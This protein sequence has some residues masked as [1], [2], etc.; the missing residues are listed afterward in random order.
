MSNLENFAQAVTAL[1]EL[2]D[3]NAKER[4]DLNAEY[5]AYMKKRRKAHCD[6]EYR[7]RAEGMWTEHAKA[8]EALEF[9][10][11]TRAESITPIA[12]AEWTLFERRDDGSYST[13]G[14]GAGRY[15]QASA[16]MSADVARQFNIPVEVR[17]I[18]PTRYTKEYGL[19]VGGCWEVYV[20]ADAITCEVLRRKPG[21]TLLE[22]VRLCW[23]RGVNPRVFNPYL[24][25]GYEEKVGLDFFG[26]EVPS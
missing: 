13:Q 24:P 23:K 9:H 21:P 25:F 6:A 3:R 20:R 17:R 5:Q 2:Q 15:A 16:E 11:V 7:Y 12:G 26:N 4:A 1:L 10:L 18:E 22:S 14:F 19:P 8:V